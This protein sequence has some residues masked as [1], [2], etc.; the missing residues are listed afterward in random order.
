MVDGKVVRTA[1]GQENEHLDWASWDVRDLQGRQAHIEIVD[2]AKGGWGHINAD[3]IV[4]SDTPP[5]CAV[6]RTGGLRF[7]GTGPAWRKRGRVG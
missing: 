5:A 6:C 1:T 3:N 7:A 2:T 4:F